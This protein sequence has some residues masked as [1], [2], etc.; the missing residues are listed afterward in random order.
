MS[1]PAC[2]PG[3]PAVRVGCTE[4][5]PVELTGPEG[6]LLGGV[7]YSGR[8]PNNGWSVGGT[9]PGAGVE[10]E[11]SVSRAGKYEASVA[12]LCAGAEAGARVRL[13]AGD[14]STEA[15]PHRTPRSQVP[16][17]D[18][19]PRTEVYEMHW[20]RL[21]LGEIH[22]PEGSTRVRIEASGKVEES[23][24]KR[25]ELRRMPDPKGP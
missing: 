10:W 1:L 19:F 13:R 7:R 17:P 21:A 15:M 18:R 5:N 9:Q 24:L 25:L 14:A 8:H 12:F 4:E 2:A 11:V 20:Q 6:R 23:E 16:S 3:S 22:L